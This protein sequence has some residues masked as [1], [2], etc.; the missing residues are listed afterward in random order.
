MEKDRGVGTQE[1]KRQKKAGQEA[2]FPRWWEVGKIVKKL[3]S[4]A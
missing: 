4:I 3:S 2:G 1:K